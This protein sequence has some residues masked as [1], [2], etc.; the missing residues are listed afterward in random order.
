MINLTVVNEKKEQ[1]LPFLMSLPIRPVDYAMMIVNLILKKEGKFSW[2]V[3]AGQSTET[4]SSRR[5]KDAL[6]MPPRSKTAFIA[7]AR[8]SCS[9]LAS[10]VS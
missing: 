7:G 5:Y 1:I 8:V 9:M 4:P 3:G 10:C 6:I 2:E